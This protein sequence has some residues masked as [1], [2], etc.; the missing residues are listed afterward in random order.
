MNFPIEAF[1]VI[2]QNNIKG[3]VI[4]KEDLKNVIITIN[5]SDLIPG[6]L[7]FHIH[8]YGDLR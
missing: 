8:Q 5:L 7:R 6:L 3:T 1:C 4:F 2:E